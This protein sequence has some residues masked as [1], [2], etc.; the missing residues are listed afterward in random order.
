MARWAFSVVLTAGV[1]AVLSGCGTLYNFSPSRSKFVHSAVKG[2]QSPYGGVCLDWDEGC[3]FFRGALSNSPEFTPSWRAL[4]VA[5][6]AWVFAVDLP[7]SAITD[8]LT[9]PVTIRA[10]LPQKAQTA[11]PS[12]EPV[13]PS[14]SASVA[15]HP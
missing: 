6:G 5:T 3:T 11:E 4:W 15:A 13:P 8:T 2:S 1:A 12:E 7:L 10:A 9:L 14:P